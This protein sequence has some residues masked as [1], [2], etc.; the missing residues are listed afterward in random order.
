MI[1]AAISPIV[2][3][4]RGAFA[5]TCGAACLAAPFYGSDGRARCSAADGV[6]DASDSPTFSPL[7]PFPTSSALPDLL[8]DVE[9]CRSLILP[10]AEALVRAARLVGTAAIMAVDYKAHYL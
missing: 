8:D 3:R 2:L 9:R 7:L 10:T 1:R 6:S 5:A 4:R